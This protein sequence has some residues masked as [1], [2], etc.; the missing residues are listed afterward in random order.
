MTTHMSCVGLFGAGLLTPSK[1]ST[2][3]LLF[4][5]I[6]SRNWQNDVGQNDEESKFRFLLSFCPPSFYP[7]EIGSLAER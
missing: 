3:G 2:E 6:K 5:F 7:T 4:N 1:R